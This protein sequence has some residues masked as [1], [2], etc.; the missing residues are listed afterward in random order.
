MQRVDKLSLALVSEGDNTVQEQG[1]TVP[2]KKGKSC[3]KSRQFRLTVSRNVD[4]AVLWCDG[5]HRPRR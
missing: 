3:E 2:T 4:L 5:R 1:L